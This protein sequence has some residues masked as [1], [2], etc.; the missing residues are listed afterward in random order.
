MR[1]FTFFGNPNI[2]GGFGV[3]MLPLIAG[4]II[5]SFNKGNK[6]SAY[7]LLGIFLL[8]LI[9][10]AMSQTR[11]SWLA[12]VITAVV[13]FALYFRKKEIKLMKKHAL[14]TG[15]IVVLV[16]IL[17]LFAFNAFKSSRLLDNTTVNLR[18]FYYSNTFDMIKENPFFGRGVG[19]FDVY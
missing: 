14:F 15:I 16:V 10:L 6:K 8:N 2:L 3:F 19:S 9:S 1:T 17:T 12:F 5:D 7:V 4:F 18:F 13:F 11:G